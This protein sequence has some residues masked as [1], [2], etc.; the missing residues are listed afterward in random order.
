VGPA[1]SA[2]LALDGPVYLRLGKKGEPR[3]HDAPPAVTLGEPLAVRAGEQVCLLACGT[4]LPLALAAADQL[5]A[6]GLSTAVFSH[7]T[8]KPLCEPFLADAFTRYRVVATVEEHSVIGGLGSAVAE[9]LAE[10]ERPA[11]RFCR[12]AVPDEFLHA[13]GDQHYYR[14]QFGLTPEAISARVRATCRAY[15]GGDK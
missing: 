14:Q 8:V 10:R 6:G 1:L 3:V 4:V 7:H 2:A 12:C 9:W 13:A 5:A 11:A 15:P